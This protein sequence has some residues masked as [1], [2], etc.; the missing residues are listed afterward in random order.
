MATVGDQRPL[1]PLAAAHE[2]KLGWGATPGIRSRE[3]WGAEFTEHSQMRAVS[4]RLHGRSIRLP[5]APGLVRPQRILEKMNEV[6]AEI[7]IMVQIA[8]NWGSP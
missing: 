6:P 8:A 4:C 3:F 5:V 1:V 2:I 7:I